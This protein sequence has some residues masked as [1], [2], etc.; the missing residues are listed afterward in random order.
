MSYLFQF[1]AFIFGALI[2]SF[3]NVVIL[4]L[5][6]KKDLALERSSCPKCGTLIKWYQNIPLLSFL[7]LRG[8][9]RQCRAKISWQYP[10][11]ELGT[12]FLS[13]FLFPST[14]SSQSLML[15]L[16]YFF[17]GCIFICHFVI[18]LR[19]QLLLDK[20]NIALLVIVLPFVIFFKPYQ[21]WVLGGVVGFMG[22]F[23]VSW[24]FYKLKG[25]VGLGGG[26]IKLWGILGL[27]LGPIGVIH[28]IFLS[29][30]LG[31]LIGLSLIALK[32]LKKNQAIPFGPFILVVA[33]VQLYF[34]W[35]LAEFSSLFLIP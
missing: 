31:S 18:D 19:H 21:N 9:C 1:Y 15:Y 28:N 32:L 13:L 16:V 35:V 27:M 14:L 20:L 6:E 12:A 24:L 34:P 7:F 26:D 29:C 22:P 33:T 17:I 2:G 11:V 4:R 25:Q 3:L 8:R 23:T 5:P 30:L 10:L